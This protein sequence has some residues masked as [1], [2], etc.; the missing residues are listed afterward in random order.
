MFISEALSFLHNPTHMTFYVRVIL[1]RKRYKI[2]QTD[3]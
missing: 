3:S 2:W 1:K